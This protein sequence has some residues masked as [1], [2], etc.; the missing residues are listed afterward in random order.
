[1]KR[2]T[3]NRLEREALALFEEYRFSL[4]LFARWTAADWRAR[5]DAA[6]W[7]LAHQMGWDVTDFGSGRFAERGLVVFFFVRNGRQRVAGEKPYA[8]KLLVVREDQ[9]TPFHTRKG[10][11]GGHHRPRRR[12]PDDGAA[13]PPP[14]FANRAG[15]PG[16][17]MRRAPEFSG[18]PLV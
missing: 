18:L 4:P 5:P 3:I 9:E 10:Q 12:Q 1:M 13:Q 15:A 8:E 14:A 2:S 16:R 6:A 7:C 17:R 11:D